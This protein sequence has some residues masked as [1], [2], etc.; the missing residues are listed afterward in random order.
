MIARSVPSGPGRDQQPP[1]LIRRQV[2]A[3]ALMSI[4]GCDPITL[5]ETPVGTPLRHAIL[6]LQLLAP[7]SSTLD[8]THLL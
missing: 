7:S 4:D 6:P 8:E 1:H 3:R 5:D 2:I